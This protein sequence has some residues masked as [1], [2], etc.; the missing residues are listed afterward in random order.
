MFQDAIRSAAEHV[1]SFLGLVPGHHSLWALALLVAIPVAVALAA[2][3][4]RDWLLK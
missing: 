3:L 2:A 4:L 1:S